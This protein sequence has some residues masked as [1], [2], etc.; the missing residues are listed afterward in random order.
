MSSRHPE[1]LQ[2]AATH[3]FTLLPKHGLVLLP[4]E[5]REC[6][7][8][9]SGR[10][11]LREGPG[12]PRLARSQERACSSGERSARGELGRVG[13]HKKAQATAPAGQQL[14][15]LGFT[16]RRVP[17][18]STTLSPPAFTQCFKAQQKPSA[19][20]T[21]PLQ[22]TCG[23]S[24]PCHQHDAFEARIS[25]S[26]HEKSLGNFVSRREDKRSPGANGSV[27][28]WAFLQQSKGRSAR[29]LP[30]RLWTLL[31]TLHTSRTAFSALAATDTQR[32]PDK[33][34]PCAD[35]FGTEL[36]CF[37]SREGMSLS[38]PCSF[39]LRFYLPRFTI[40]CVPLPNTT[41]PVD[42]EIPQ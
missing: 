27:I 26:P 22:L 23:R 28:N 11:Q 14:Y 6:W 37:F 38:D 39:R 30:D 31:P 3:G 15:S 40:S 41:F 2:R 10:G 7:E 4:R 13:W 9:R 35:P 36:S 16:T 33:L 5:G 1:K 34:C 20:L 24:A 18:P 8:R 42:A 32:H 21:A 19:L 17:V 29:A 12:H 25:C